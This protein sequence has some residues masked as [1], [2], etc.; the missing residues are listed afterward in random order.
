MT[1]LRISIWINQKCSF[2]SEFYY[3]H[4]YFAFRTFFYTPIKFLIKIASIYR[5]FKQ[6]KYI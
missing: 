3:R 1:K 4:I 5:H 2:V 6:N